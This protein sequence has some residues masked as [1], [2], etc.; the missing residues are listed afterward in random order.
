MLA[1]Y[2]CGPWWAVDA[3]LWGVLT[4][5]LALL[6]PTMAL[7]WWTC[8]GWGLSIVLGFACTAVYVM[9]LYSIALTG[10]HVV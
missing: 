6:G 3:V 7:Q 2:W 9:V 10:E 1:T 8:R 4:L 5:L